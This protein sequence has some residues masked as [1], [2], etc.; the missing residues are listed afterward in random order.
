[1]VEKFPS[2][3][4]QGFLSLIPDTPKPD[5]IYYIHPK[6]KEIYDHLIRSGV[7]D[8]DIE[9]TLLVQVDKGYMVDKKEI[10]RLSYGG[11][12]PMFKIKEYEPGEM[13]HEM[14]INDIKNPSY[15]GSR[16]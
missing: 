1:M 9:M 4:P 6:N 2:S 3:T 15:F 16:A 8:K 14:L 12:Q 10:D 13:L 5:N 11:Y 7:A